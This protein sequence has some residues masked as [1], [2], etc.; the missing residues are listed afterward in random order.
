LLR[1]TAFLSH[2]Y[3]KCIILPRQARDKYREN[4]KKAAV[5]R[6]ACGRVAPVRKPAVLF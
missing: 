1:K 6:T 2:L 4:S 5:F 3:I